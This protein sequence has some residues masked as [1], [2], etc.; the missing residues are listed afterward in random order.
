[1]TIRARC[2]G[3]RSLCT[4]TNNSHTTN[5]DRTTNNYNNNSPCHTPNITSKNTDTM[6]SPPPSTTSAPTPVHVAHTKN[7]GSPLKVK[8]E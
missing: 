5:S 2:L 1:M 6:P 3:N 8:T 7:D 4:N